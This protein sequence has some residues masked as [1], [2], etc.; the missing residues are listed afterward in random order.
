MS[1][2]GVIELI[3][4]NIGRS[5]IWMD[6]NI[7]ES[8]HIHID[9]LR[10]DLSNDEFTI[11]RDDLL[12]VLCLMYPVD[13]F[14]IRTLNPAYLAFPFINKLPYLEKVKIDEVYLNDLCTAKPIFYKYWRD[15]PWR[16]IP[17]CKSRIFKALNGKNIK[18]NDKAKSMH[19]IFQTHVE[20]INTVLNSIKTNGYPYKNKYI[21]LY[22]NNM[23][24]EDGQHRAVCLLY[25]YGNI[26]IPI[27]RFYFNNG[28]LRKWTLKKKIISRLSLYLHI[29]DVVIMKNV[30]LFVKNCIKKTPFIIY[31][32]FNKE[33][34]DY[35]EKEFDLENNR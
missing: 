20:R 5:R 35:I 27:M 15:S 1:N 17:L 4:G 25:L 33:I 10:L 16:K 32:I 13:G 6:D 28:N 22:N 7:G 34:V 23:Y 19:Y 11:L 31:S 3:R 30:V 8:I 9:E 2:P 29:F 21:I 12:D 26:K 14:N 24:I 18:E